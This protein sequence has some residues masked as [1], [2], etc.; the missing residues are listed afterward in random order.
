[1]YAIRQSGADQL[2]F[3]RRLQ[4]SWLPGPRWP[5]KLAASRTA[6]IYFTLSALALAAAQPLFGSEH[7]A[8]A[9]WGT[10]IGFWV[11][12]YSRHRLR[13]P[14]PLPISLLSFSFLLGALPFIWTLN[15]EDLRVPL[16]NAAFI[17]A[18][19]G[20]AFGNREIRAYSW[21]ILGVAFV[22]LGQAFGV[23]YRHSLSLFSESRIGFNLVGRL[24]ANAGLGSL[25][26][27]PSFL[28]LLIFLAATVLVFLSAS[29]NAS[30]TLILGTFVAYVMASRRVKRELLYGNIIAA[31]LTAMPFLTFGSGLLRRL[32]LWRAER[33]LTYVN[34]D[35]AYPWSYWLHQCLRSPLG[36]GFGT[37]AHGAYPVGGHN[38]WLDLWAKGGPLCALL[39]VIAQSMLLWDLYRRRKYS[40]V[41]STTFA[42]AVGYTF[43]MIFENFQTYGMASFI[44]F[45]SAGVSLAQAMQR[46]V[47]V[48]VTSLVDHRQI[49]YPKGITNV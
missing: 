46:K 28:A 27:F 24:A 15:L 4:R 18:V 16:T 34:V 43:H 20:A 45:Y 26:A 41:H 8:V 23:L 32:P 40:P 48:S 25:S 30:A 6:E 47:L 7:P 29:R 35:R 21:I 19:G 11:L 33:A 38:A 22:T 49:G 9:A 17:Y 14:V 37:V 10:S 5:Q 3:R 1:V 42:L 2:G 13:K 44:V 12:C 31:L 36:I 39:F